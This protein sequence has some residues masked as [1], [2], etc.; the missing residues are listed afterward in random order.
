MFDFFSPEKLLLIAAVALIFV[1]PKRLPQIGRSIGRWLGDLR[2]A[3]GSIA[4]E[5]EDRS[6]VRLIGGVVEQSHARN[7]VHRLHH[8]ADDFWTTAF[9]DIRDAFDKW[10]HATSE[11]RRRRSATRA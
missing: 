5:S 8:R 3:T 4:D 10:F 11:N 7:L 6:I 2:R 9:A 1:G